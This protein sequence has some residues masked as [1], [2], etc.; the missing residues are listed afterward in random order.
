MSEKLRLFV[1]VDLPPELKEKIGKALPNFRERC[2]DVR[3]V[4]AENLHLTLKFLGHVESGK[5][6]FINRALQ[7]VCA[8][9]TPFRLRL[10]GGGA[11]PD[12]G[13]GR[14]IWV[15]IEG[16]VEK[17][18]ELAERI[19]TK[20]EELGFDREERSFRPHITLGRMKRPRP[21]RDLVEEWRA[22][23]EDMGET[24]FTAS[25]VTLFQS[26][27][28]REGPRYFPVEVFALKGD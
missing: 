23:L 19:E 6:E 20:L 16:D 21:C 9:A 15:G 22:I 1:A 2:T 13:K 27:L 3:W 12:E 28:S 17:A 7:G 4:K 18:A 24:G 10:C 5:V 11:F 25:E 8:H 26:V 14:V